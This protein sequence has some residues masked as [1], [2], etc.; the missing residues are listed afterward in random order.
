MDRKTSHD[1]AQQEV[2]QKPPLLDGEA[3]VD[4]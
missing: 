2:F 1:P 3:A 4:L